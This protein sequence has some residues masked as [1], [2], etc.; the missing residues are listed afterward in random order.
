M[1]KRLYSTIQ[2]G[3]KYTNDFKTYLK[4]DNGKIGSF[5]HD[6]P[7]NYNPTDKTVNM[8]VEIPRWT[9]GKF[10]IN[11]DLPC[12]PIIQD[13]KKGKLRFVNNIY[14]HHGYPH[15][16]GAIPRT[17][18]NSTK[19]TEFSKDLKLSGDNDPLDIIDIGSE[20][21]KIGDIKKIKILGSL[22]LIDD[23][24][25]DW[26]IIGINST[27]KLFNE[28]HNL[29]DVNLKMPNL[30]NDIKRWFK[31][32]KLPTGKSENNFAFNG[33]FKDQ[34][35]TIN[36]INECHKDWENLIYN[37]I[38]TSETDNLP[39]NLNSTIENSPGF[40]EFNESDLNLKP[41]GKDADIPKDVDDVFYYK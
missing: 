4:L 40:T 1:L 34:D 12:N 25:L 20:I 27:D 31:I 30:L 29:N 2:S 28:L 5:F 36:I 9:N 6:V 22:A 19:I 10:E 41:I 33:E 14:P 35:F 3:S 38:N 32:Y 16:Y 39:I 13:T 37:K 8:V 11:G 26:K 18:E 21:L 7:I 17:W 15:N 24:E 23:G